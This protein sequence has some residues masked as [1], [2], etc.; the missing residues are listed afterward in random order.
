LSLQVKSSGFYKFNLQQIL[1]DGNP[2]KPQDSGDDVQNGTAHIS[3]NRLYN[4]V[5]ANQAGQHT[6]TILAKPGFQ[7]FTFTFG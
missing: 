4:I 7:M 1:L 3:E 6:L 2:I 5:S